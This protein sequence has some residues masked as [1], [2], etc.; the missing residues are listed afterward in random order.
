VRNLVYEIREDEVLLDNYY[1]LNSVEEV[2]IFGEWLKD[3]GVLGDWSRLQMGEDGWLK[4]TKISGEKK[5]IVLSK[6][7]I[8]LL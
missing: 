6:R 8:A 1:D 2:L 5:I 3:D 4:T 7:A